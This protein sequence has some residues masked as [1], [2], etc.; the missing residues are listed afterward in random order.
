MTDSELFSRPVIGVSL[1]SRE[2]TALSLARGQI[3]ELV[4]T[5]FDR[6]G[7]PLGQIVNIINS[8]RESGID[9]EC[10]GIAVPGLVNRTTR[11]IADSTDFPYFVDVDLKSEL[12]RAVGVSVAVENDANAAG[13]AE[14]R[15]G[16]GQTSKQMFYV[17]LGDGVGGSFIFDG[18]IWNGTSGFA[19]EFGS[20]AIDSEGTRLESVASSAGII[21]RTVERMFQ[22]STS[23]LS[24]YGE[25]DLTIK[26]LVE[27]ALNG[28]DLAVM[29]LERTG[30][31]IGTALSSVINL[32]NVDLVVVGGKIVEAGEAILGPIRN[33]AEALSFGPS[34]GDV[35]IVAGSLGESAAA[36]GAAL[37]VSR[38]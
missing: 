5:D 14:Y 8:V 31:H 13:F 17:Y 36:L 22:D 27:A 15:L 26:G 24:R 4:R 30:V 37:L 29:M 10:V 21:S 9:A 33:R 16:A 23:D 20:V 1:S 28:D 12:A 3:G 35:T 34:F 38:K 6:E 7:D 18:Q 25:D 2:L 32:L 11:E 19:G